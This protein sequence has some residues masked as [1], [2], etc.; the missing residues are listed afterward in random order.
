MCR[1]MLIED[2]YDDLPPLISVEDD[3][4]PFQ[5][6]QILSEENILNYIHY[7]ENREGN[8]GFNNVFYIPTSDT[9][10]D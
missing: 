9:R 4:I 6:S 3:F 5:Q 8:R 2:D 10:T 7:V 1:E